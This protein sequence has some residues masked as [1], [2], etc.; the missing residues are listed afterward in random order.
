M[1]IKPIVSQFLK[2]KKLPYNEDTYSSRLW[3]FLQR[4]EELMVHAPPITELGRTGGKTLTPGGVYVGVPEVTPDLVI[5]MQEFIKR[6]ICQ[7][8]ADPGMSSDAL[9]KCPVM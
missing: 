6:I 5:A 3:L 1:G 4:Y 9:E 7:R 2:Q 8:Q